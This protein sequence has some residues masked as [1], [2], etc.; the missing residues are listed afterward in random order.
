MPAGCGYVSASCAGVAGT[1]SSL[2][3]R[4]PRPRCRSTTSSCRTLCSRSRAP[5]RPTSAAAAT[6]VQVSHAPCLACCVGRYLSS[7]VVTCCAEQR[8]VSSARQVA[9]TLTRD[10]V[11][12]LTGVHKDQLWGDI[13]VVNGVPW[14]VLD[15]KSTWHRFRVLNASPSRPWNL[16]VGRQACRL[17]SPALPRSLHVHRLCHEAIMMSLTSTVR[18]TSCSFPAVPRRGWQGDRQQEVLHHRQR[19]RH[20][21]QRRQ[22]HAARRRPAD[23]C[24]LPLGHHLRLH[25]LHC[26]REHPAACVQ[27]YHHPQSFQSL[28]S[29]LQVGKRTN[30]LLTY[31]C[32]LPSI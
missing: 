14:P 4:G 16:Q 26:R 19:R 1:M 2:M 12:G 8:R 29:H 5:A 9:Q 18:N 7:K 24:G 31:Q 13:N 23:G 17:T 3:R 28:V 10:A 22:A 27:V 11:C 15:I 30:N 6:T 32:R 21:P 25:W 20:C